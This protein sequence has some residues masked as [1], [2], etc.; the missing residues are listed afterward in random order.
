MRAVC[1]GFQLWDIFEDTRNAKGICDHRAPVWRA[2]YTVSIY[3][4]IPNPFVF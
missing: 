4:W 3:R 2:K 1:V